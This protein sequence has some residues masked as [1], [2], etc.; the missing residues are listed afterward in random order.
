MQVLIYF[1]GICT[2]ICT[3]FSIIEKNPIYSILFLLGSFIFISGILFSI[4]SC[5]PAIIE[6]VIYSGAVIVLFIFVIMMLNL[7]EICNFQKK[8][9]TTYIFTLASISISFLFFIILCKSIFSLKIL[10]LKPSTIT[11]KIIGSKLFSKYYLIVELISILLLS[12]L[13]VSFKIGKK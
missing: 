4:G 8:K 12:A 5:F 9:I 11:T 2:T 7:K 3:F 1:L 10:S 13:I 6:L